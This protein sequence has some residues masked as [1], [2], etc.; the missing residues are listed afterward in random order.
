MSITTNTKARTQSETL[1]QLQGLI[2]GLQKQLPGGS[3][4]LVSTVFPT[5]TL[6]TA[7]QGTVTTLLAVTAAHAALK[8]TLAAWDAEEAKMGPV[9]LALR[10]ILQSMYANAPDTLAVYGMEPRKVPA[11]RTAAQKAATAAK[12]AATR[13]ARGT[14]SKKAKSVITGNVTGVTITPVTAPT[15]APTVQ[16]VTA[17]PATP[18]AAPPAAA[19]VVTSAAPVSPPGHVGQ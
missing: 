3:F 4:T 18:A 11:P 8:V 17:Q 9:V 2:L 1:A 7:L 12:A 16:P 15:A 19:Q 13:I 5:A 6:V 10:R 14:A